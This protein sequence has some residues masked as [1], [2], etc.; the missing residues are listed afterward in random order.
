MY[1][2]LFLTPF[3]CVVFPSL[4]TETETNFSWKGRSQNKPDRTK[5]LRFRMV[6][7]AFHSNIKPHK[8][9]VNK[10][11][12]KLY[13]GNIR[14][15]TV[16]FRPTCDAL[17]P[18][19][20]S[21]VRQSIRYHREKSWSLDKA[22]YPRWHD[23]K[24]NRICQYSVRMYTFWILEPWLLI[25]KLIIPDTES[26]L[27]RPQIPCPRNAW[28]PGRIG[29]S[30][31]I[32]LNGLLLRT[33]EYRWHVGHNQHTGKISTFEFPL[34]KR[35]VWCINHVS[36]MHDTGFLTQARQSTAYGSKAVGLF[37]SVPERT[38]SK[39]T[40]ALC[41]QLPVSNR[42]DE[43]EIIKKISSFFVDLMGNPWNGLDSL[44]HCVQN[45][46]WMK[47]AETGW[48]LG[49]K[50]QQECQAR[51]RGAPWDWC[52]CCH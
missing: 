30:T 19:I 50:Q 33:S 27:L 22:T 17:F 49:E 24:W 51:R 42:V 32:D 43:L 52:K 6:R 48:H 8:G 4:K 47:L 13:I 29:G 2:C 20:I 35:D 37:L 5:R 25:T 26:V 12:S 38:S 23:Y 39:V 34:L 7:N 16:N 3:F 14:A 11:M 31:I 21:T 36:Q 18:L 15:V 41:H 40:S 28:S 10:K 46:C 1:F 45:G 44:H 9:W